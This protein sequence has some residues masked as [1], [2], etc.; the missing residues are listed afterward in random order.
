VDPND[1]GELARDIATTRERLAQLLDRA[2]RELENT[3]VLAEQHA[4]RRSGS[5]DDDTRELELSRARQARE[6]AR[7]ARAN[8]QRVRSAAPTARPD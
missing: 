1:E 8:A 3:A 2:A 6:Y 4:A 5:V 7:R